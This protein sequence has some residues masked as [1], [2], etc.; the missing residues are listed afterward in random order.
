MI[1]EIIEDFKAVSENSNRMVWR[2]YEKYK[3]KLIFVPAILWED[4]MKGE[5]DARIVVYKDQTMTVGVQYDITFRDD[6]L[7]RVSLTEDIS[8]LPG[9][10][11]EI[12]QAGHFREGGIPCDL[13][14]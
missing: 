1:M 8:G 14:G 5:M 7:I 3:D 2:E 13:E 10:E 4:R 9:Y 6:K 12:S 11:K